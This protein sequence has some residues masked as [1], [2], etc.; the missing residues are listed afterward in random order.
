[1][2]PTRIHTLRALAL[3]AMIIGVVAAVAVLVLGMRDMF[4]NGIRYGM[5]F[6]SHEIANHVIRKAMYIMLA[7]LLLCQVLIG[8]GGFARYKLKKMLA[9]QTPS[10]TAI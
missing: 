10:S 7:K 3:V 8:G 6:E 2:T 5:T 1:M 4:A 9:A